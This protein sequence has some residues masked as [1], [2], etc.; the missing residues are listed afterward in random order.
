M[1]FNNR[2]KQ[3]RNDQCQQHK[4]CCRCQGKHHQSICERPFQPVG[5]T[6]QVHTN[7][8]LGV[9]SRRTNEERT[10]LS[11]MIPAQPQ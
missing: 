10:E 2:L 8:N 6:P 9:E 1:S 4:S 11:E 7:S 5:S 3:E